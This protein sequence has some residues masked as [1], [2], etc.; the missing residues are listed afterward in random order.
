MQGSPLRD[1][2]R[3]SGLGIQMAISLG[4]PIYGGWWLDE[5]YASSP[6]GILGGIVFGLVSIFSLL[7]KLTLQSGKKP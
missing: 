5:R 1:Y 7:Y 3:Y 4:L 6:W 2:A